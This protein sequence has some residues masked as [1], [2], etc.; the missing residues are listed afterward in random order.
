MTVWVS[1]MRHACSGLADRVSV[2]HRTTSIEIAIK[3]RRHIRPRSPGRARTERQEIMKAC[4]PLLRCSPADCH[5]GT[6]QI[7]D[8]SAAS[9]R[10]SNCPLRLGE[11][12]RSRPSSTCGMGGRARAAS[13]TRMASENV[14]VDANRVLFAKRSMLEKLSSVTAPN[15]PRLLTRR[16]HGRVKDPSRSPL[17][18]CVQQTLRSCAAVLARFCN[19]VL[20]MMPS[21]RVIC[22]DQQFFVKGLL[23]ISSHWVG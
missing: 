13:D 20:L 5:P 15:H 16:R 23:S 1:S 17:G 8:G 22:R 3:G 12:R 14:H 18:D 6:R 9:P 2:Q 4:G 7:R 21:P 11:C 10:P 19:Y